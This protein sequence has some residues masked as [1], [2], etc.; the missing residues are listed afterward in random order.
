MQDITGY[1]A[2]FREVIGGIILEDLSEDYAVAQSLSLSDKGKYIDGLLPA[3]EAERVRYYLSS[4]R[5]TVFSQSYIKNDGKSGIWKVNAHIEHPVAV[6]SGT[7]LDYPGDRDTLLCTERQLMRDE[8]VV[9]MSVGSGN[10][11]VYKS[12]N[13]DAAAASAGESISSLLEKLGYHI[14]HCRKTGMCR[15]LCLAAGNDGAYLRLQLMPFSIGE[16]SFTML[17][18]SNVSFRCNR[19]AQDLTDAYLI[20]ICMIDISEENDE[21]FYDINP[22]MCRLLFSKDITKQDIVSSY[23]FCSALKQ[24]STRFGIV[25]L[26]SGNFLL[27][28]VPVFDNNGNCRMTV[29]AIRS[30]NTQIVDDSCFDRLT[31]REGNVVRLTL[32]GMSSK[33]IGKALGISEGTVKRELFS[34]CKKLEVKGKIGMLMKMYHLK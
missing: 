32:E 4:Y 13:A 23:P 30:D 12:R 9:A 1:R 10:I 5:G 34:S 24:G 15:R 8:V 17:K 7:R 21:F 20:G 16:G 19:S 14:M 22:Y 27:G 3:A 25:S 18:L 2:V 6:L 29:L 26:K 33:S 11:A 31:P 28:A